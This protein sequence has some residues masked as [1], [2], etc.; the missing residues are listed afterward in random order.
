MTLFDSNQGNIFISRSALE[1]DG[2]IQIT[3]VIDWQHTAVLPLYLTAHIP[4]FI[5]QAEP[6]PEQSEDVLQKEKAY[7]R[8]AYHALYQETGL[9]VVW[10]SSLSFGGKFPM[11]Q[12][13]PAAAQFCWHGGY[14][15][16]KRLLISV[17]EEW[18][19]VGP[20][21]PCP[22]PP[23]LLSK[24][25]AA[26]AELDEAAWSEMESARDEITRAV[27]VEDDGWVSNENYEK[28][29][30]AN[31]EL[32]ALWMESVRNTDVQGMGDVDLIDIWPFREPDEQHLCADKNAR[33]ISIEPS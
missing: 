1:R 22:L 29:V 14:V 12:Q 8:K 26:Q 31:A 2:T 28:A 17:A 10:A 23:E 11:A 16:L 4:R 7:L 20:G 25:V 5:E 32:R 21:I 13:M 15:K 6:A 27:G 18:N 30:K 24:E 9:D 33:K 3:S 19:I